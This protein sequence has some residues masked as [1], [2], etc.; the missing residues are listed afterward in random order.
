M[1]NRAG[2]RD[3]PFTPTKHYRHVCYRAVTAADSLQLGTYVLTLFYVL[4]MGVKIMK[5]VTLTKDAHY[6]ASWV[7]NFEPIP[8]GTVVPVVP[9]NNLPDCEGKYWVNTPELEN[10]PY[11]ILLLPGDYS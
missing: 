3:G 2:H 11:G 10:D 8:A 6:P 1:F 4:T 7:F 9:A 5:H